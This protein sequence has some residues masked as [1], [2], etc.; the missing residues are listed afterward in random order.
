MITYTSFFSLHNAYYS[1]CISQVF[2]PLHTRHTIFWPDLVC[3]TVTMFFPTLCQKFLD[4]KSEKLLILLTLLKNFLPV[5]FL[6]IQSYN[7]F[8]RCC[9]LSAFYCSFFSSFNFFFPRYSIIS[10]LRLSNVS[11][12]G[13]HFFARRL[14]DRSSLSTF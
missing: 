6:L 13:Y 9:W 14:I 5:Q 4:S 1:V 7:L 12:S 2:P 8:L 10:Y 11:S 3:Y